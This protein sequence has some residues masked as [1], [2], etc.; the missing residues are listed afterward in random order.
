MK[1]CVGFTHQQGTT[2]KRE[3]GYSHRYGDL[4][5]L[6]QFL[7]TNVRDETLERNFPGIQL[8]HLKKKKKEYHWIISCRS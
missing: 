7:L 3:H 4:L 1:K 5:E 8:D 2:R 6:V